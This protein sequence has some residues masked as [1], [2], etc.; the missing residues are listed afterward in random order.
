M[1]SNALNSKGL[2]L[3]HE[4]GR[5]DGV[6][7]LTRLFAG[8]PM[9]LKTMFLRAVLIASAIWT[10]LFVFKLTLGQ[11][12][13]A[14]A[15]TAFFNTTS[16]FDAGRKNYA[17]LKQSGG[18]LPQAGESQKYEKVATIGQST[19]NF[20]ADRA[21]VDAAITAS[22]G[23]T[24]YELL[25]GLTGFRTL[26]LT[27][28]IPPQKF[29]AF[30]EEVRKIA[31]NT[32]LVIVKT[33]KTNE[34]R[35]LRARRE[36]LEKTR[37]ALT[38][39]AS[40]GGSID[41]RLKVQ[42]QLAQVEDKLQDLGVALGDFNAENEFCTVKLTLAEAASKIG[43]SLALRAFHAAVWAT[44]YFVRIA[45]GLL[46]IALAVWLSTLVIGLLFRAWKSVTR[47]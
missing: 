17:S 25:Q 13:G 41:E 14:P 29:D 21:K 7:H 16:N 37:Q 24:Q 20:D 4:T 22:G 12:E 39:M 35:Q 42:A 1:V 44:E 5:R 11:Q 47:G 32:Q 33:D 8:Y 27:I 9:R 45:A 15:A 28:G 18:I 43:P 10:A 46:M 30:V 19:S 26:N 23:L 34:Y 3:W 40:S 36:T 6:A 38:E 31:K 2:A